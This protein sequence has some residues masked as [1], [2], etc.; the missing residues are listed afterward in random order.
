MGLNTNA[1]KVPCGMQIGRCTITNQSL[2]VFS[3]ESQ[4]QKKTA[5]AL[6]ENS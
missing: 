4:S 6:L 5:V 2:L 3:I 1:G